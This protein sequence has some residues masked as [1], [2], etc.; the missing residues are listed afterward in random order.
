MTGRTCLMIL[1][2]CLGRAA[3]ASAQEDPPPPRFRLERLPDWER[4]YEPLVTDLAD[5]DGDGDLDITELARRSDGPHVWSQRGNG[6]ALLVRAND[7]RARFEAPSELPLADRFGTPMGRSRWQAIAFADVDADG[8][9][10]AVAIDD[11]RLR[12]FEN[13]EVESRRV[14]ADA[15]PPQLADGVGPAAWLGWQGEPGERELLVVGRAAPIGVHRL[16]RLGDWSA[17][18]PERVAHGTLRSEAGAQSLQLEPAT[19]QA[20]DWIDYDGDGHLDLAHAPWTM[21]GI[22]ILRLFAGDEAGDLHEVTS[23]RIPVA[24]TGEGYGC[25]WG[26]LD[27]DAR[28]E[29]VMANYGLVD[30]PIPNVT[31]PEVVLRQTADH[32]LEIVPEPFGPEPPICNASVVKL[33][34]LDLDGRLD[35][36]VLPFVNCV[37]YAAIN[38]G[39]MHFAVEALP[40]LAYGRQLA[41]GD[42]D[43]DGDVDF[44][45]DS[46]G[47]PAVTLNLTR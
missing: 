31:E 35:L 41:L 6:D 13:R 9:A 17:Q 5:V 30:G 8:D 16:T 7:G 38:A 39:G 45:T 23:E 40:V 15:S 19:D 10:D 34:D 28:P 25:A 37:G 14:F 21:G 26:D 3:T 36:V 18:G 42:L 47:R 20:L 11:G 4:G 32:R 29:L 46:L 22:P 27:G 12:T 1:L 24:P 2:A 44:V 43:G 33:A